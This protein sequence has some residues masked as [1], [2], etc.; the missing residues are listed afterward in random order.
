MSSRSKKKN[1]ARSAGAIASLALV[2]AAPVQPSDLP[3]LLAKVGAH[4]EKVEQQV[5]VLDYV[6]HSVD[7][8]LSESG[9]VLHRVEKTRKVVQS[10][11]KRRQEIVKVVQDGQDVTGPA[12]LAAQGQPMD[13]PGNPHPLLPAEQA[14]YQFELLAPDPAHPHWARVSFAPKGAPSPELMVGEALVDPETGFLR[15]LRLHPSNPPFGT[16]KMDVEVDYD[17][18]T[19]DGPLQSRMVANIEARMQAVHQRLRSTVT[20]RFETRAH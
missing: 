9:E 2:A 11:G 13:E 16:E 15:R 5:R 20:Y 17:Q 7:E 8:Q 6:E 18:L 12:R 1:A 3:A 14:R 10:E 19:P 4:V